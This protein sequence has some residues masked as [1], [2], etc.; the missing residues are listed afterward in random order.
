VRA[1]W[2]ETFHALLKEL[3]SAEEAEVVAKMPCGL[4]SF[5]RIRKITGHTKTE[6]RN[7]LERVCAKGL[8]VDLWI[9]D[10]YRYTPSPLV[11]GIFEF[12]M[13][14]TGNNCDSKRWARLF[15]QYMQ[16]DPLFYQAN[17]GSDEKISIART[18]PYEE[19]VKPS[20]YIEVLDYEKAAAIV[21]ASDTFAIGVCSCRHEKS[22]VGAKRCEVP[23]DTCSAFGAA[24]DYL[25]R[26]H[27]AKAVSKSEMLENLARSKELGLVLNADNVRRN[28]TFICHC[29]DCCC[30]L[31][32]GINQFGLSNTLVTSSFI[33]SSNDDICTGCGS[34]AQACPV[35][36]IEMLPTDAPQPG[37]RKKPRIDTSICLGCGVCSLKCKPGA[38]KLV[39]RR[40]RVLHPATTFERVILQCLERGTLQN[41]IFDNPQSDTQAFMRGLLGAFLKLSPV[42]KAL[43]SD[44]LRSSFLHAMKAGIKMQG[45]GWVTE[46]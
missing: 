14:R 19:A 31:I 26:H 20:E 38:L 12:T 25:I 13:M 3:Y 44:T 16:G 1:P 5:E 34:C 27:F 33:A 46:W 21:E 18:L 36:A 35:Y 29:C 6:L 10:E 2:N 37:P 42:K 23:L 8:V 24:A 39:K 7:T 30:N 15:H 4:A 32:A 45:N 41:Q 40:Q 22:H 9:N 43:M 17:F 28:I 11:I